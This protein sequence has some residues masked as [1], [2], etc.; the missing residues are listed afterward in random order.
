M[1]KKNLKKK[2]KS[3]DSFFVSK[4]VLNRG[5]VSPEYEGPEIQ[6][7]YEDEDL[8]AIHK[9]SNIHGHPLSYEEKNNC[10]S[11]F[12]QINYF[13]VL[14]VE[15]HKAE[16]GMLYRLDFGTSGVLIFFKNDKYAKTWRDQFHS[17]VQSKKYLAIVEGDGPKM[18]EVVN[19][20]TPS[21]PKNQKMIAGLE[22]NMDSRKAVLE[23]EGKTTYGDFSLLEI[24]LKTGLRHQIRSQLSFL[25]FP[26][27]GD[28][29]YEGKENKELFLHAF[30]YRF[31]LPNN[32]YKIKSEMP[33][34]FRDF[35]N[36]NG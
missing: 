15:K 6:I 21:G 23:I 35:L 27:I 26:I 18:G 5:L 28:S 1:D 32:E 9:P 20:L 7:L 34:R 13:D 12:R 24:S 30:E 22:E 29:L 10:L 25:G 17:L 31:S 14:N 8:V 11:F 36:L 4:N 2:I 3:K 19:Y 16:K 33:L